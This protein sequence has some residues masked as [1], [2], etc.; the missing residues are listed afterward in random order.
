MI[1]RNCGQE[2]S[3]GSAFCPNC[4]QAVR[5]NAGDISHIFKIL[6]FWFQL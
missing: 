2:I 4:G 5:E 6:L 1:C 3:E